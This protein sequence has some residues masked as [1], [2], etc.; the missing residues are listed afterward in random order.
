MPLHNDKLEQERNDRILRVTLACTIIRAVGI[1]RIA[2]V[3]CA[4]LR[5]ALTR[6]DGTGHD[7]SASADERTMN[8][9]MVKNVCYSIPTCSRLL[10]NCVVC[11]CC[12]SAV[13]NDFT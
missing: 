6:H 8:A 11:V 12:L 2:Y 9:T 7:M 4:V 10:V 1:V 5:H 13:I 3:M